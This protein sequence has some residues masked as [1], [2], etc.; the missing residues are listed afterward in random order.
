[1][2]Y[3]VNIIINQHPKNRTFLFVVLALNTASY[4][5]VQAVEN[6]KPTQI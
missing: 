2:G 1:M 3:I 4:F 5:N 6:L